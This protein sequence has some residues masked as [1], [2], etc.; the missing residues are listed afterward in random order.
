MRA[1]STPSPGGIRVR[2]K[3]ESIV[4]AE[5]LV[6]AGVG[7]GRS[8]AYP[9][10]TGP[11]GGSVKGFLFCPIHGPVF[12]VDTISRFP[13]R[14]FKWETPSWNFC[15][16]RSHLLEEMYHCVLQL[17]KKS[18]GTTKDAVHGFGKESNIVKPVSQI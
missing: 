16:S 10:S 5:S 1:F 18:H 11:E 6:P 4:H 8:P 2:L 7:A 13:L 9:G 15:Q 3:E 12:L 14:N 17:C